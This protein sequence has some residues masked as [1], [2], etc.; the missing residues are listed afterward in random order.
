[1]K[2]YLFTI[3]LTAAITFALTWAVWRLSLRFKLYPTIRERDVHTTPTPRLGGV[4]IFLG[5]AAAIGF[6][7]AN[8]FFATMWM[9]PQTMW[10]ILAASLLIA[11]ISLR[12]GLLLRPHGGT[13]GVGAAQ[14]RFV[15]LAHGL[16]Y[17]AKAASAVARWTPSSTWPISTAR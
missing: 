17:F 4:A 10:S 7:A 3:I 16:F 12:A 11:V 8:P 2:Q 1:M 13:L 5:I 6:S 15:L 14:L 9:P